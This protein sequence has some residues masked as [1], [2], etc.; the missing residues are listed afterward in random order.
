MRSG[1]AGAASP[2]GPS[3]LFCLVLNACS[4]SVLDIADSRGRGDV[5]VGHVRE[6]PRA[7][8]SL[9][10]LCGRAPFS[11]SSSVVTQVSNSRVWPSYTSSAPCTSLLYFIH[12]ASTTAL[13]VH[14]DERV[15]DVPEPAGCQSRQWTTYPAH[16]LSAT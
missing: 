13:I 8:I 10:A 16:A 7:A 15:C 14:G 4:N 1:A 2:P 11:T 6:L 9:A 5:G 12:I 3:R